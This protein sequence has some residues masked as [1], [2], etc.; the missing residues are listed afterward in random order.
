MQPTSHRSVRWTRSRSRPSRR[1]AKRIQTSTKTR[2]ITMGKKQRESQE[3]PAQELVRANAT[4]G[5]EAGIRTLG[6]Q[7]ALTGFR[8]Q[9]VRPLR[10]LSNSRADVAHTICRHSR[11][12][13]M[14]VLSCVTH[15]HQEL[16]VG[17]AAL[18]PLEHEV[19]RLEG[20]HLGQHLAER[21][22]AFELLGV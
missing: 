17:L 20:V 22:D 19:H 6:G 1:R 2:T 12:V 21:P 18:H 3:R 9:P 15:A 10:H 5:G 11:Y 4:T 7:L 13:K 14:C 8:N 16:G